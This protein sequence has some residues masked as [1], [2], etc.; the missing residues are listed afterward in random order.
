MVRG[1]GVHSSERHV[2]Q[3]KVASLELE[4]S[5][6]IKERQA[7]LRRIQEIDSRLL[8][9][10]GLLARHHQAL[11]LVSVRGVEPEA[12]SARAEQPID[13]PREGHVLRY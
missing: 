12:R 5:R 1:S 8:E 2:R 9:I 10:D 13:P 4:R 7:T 11:G 6:R 3:F